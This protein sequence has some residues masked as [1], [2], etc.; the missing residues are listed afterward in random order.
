MIAS[1]IAA[2]ASVGSCR[3]QALREPDRQFIEM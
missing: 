3:D 1:A 2:S